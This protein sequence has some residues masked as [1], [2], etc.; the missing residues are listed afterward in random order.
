MR[1]WIR[2][3]RQ[4]ILKV[5]GS[6]IALG[7]LLF[8]LEQ[9]SWDEV[10]GAARQITWLRFFSTIGLMVLSRLFIV[11]RWHILLR[12]GGVKISIKQTTSL[13]FTG[14]FA[15]NFLPTT[16]GGDIIRVGGTIQLGYNRARCAASVVVDRLIGMFGMA[17]VLPFGLVALGQWYSE[18]P[19]LLSG[20]LPFNKWIQRA[21]H[22]LKRLLESMRL[23]L[24]EPV[25]LLLALLF[26]WGHMICLFSSL[27]IIAHGVGESITFWELAWIWSLAYFITLLPISINGYGMQELSLTYLLSSV[28]AMTLANSLVVAILIRVLFIIASLPGAIFLPGI[29]TKINDKSNTL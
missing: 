7:A 25:A 14:L 5:L 20:A 22:I 17:M 4:T 15:S 16:I 6:L 10:L 21:T 18:S 8:L 12:S 29:L 23:W 13:S 1:Y 3:H 26:S 9:Q 2:S 11:M 27:F 24:K 28:G 19:T